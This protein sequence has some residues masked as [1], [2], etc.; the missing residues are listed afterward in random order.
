[1]PHVTNEYENL[2][3]FPDGRIDYTHSRTAPIVSCVIEYRDK[4]LIVKRSKRVSG[5]AGKWDVI[6]GYIDNPNIS[7]IEHTVVELEE[8]IGINKDSIAEIR[9]KDAYSYY[10]SFID[11]TWVVYPVRVTLR[12]RPNIKLNGENSDFI[13][14]YPEDIKKYDV[15]PE[16]HKSVEN[17]LF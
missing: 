15:V 9:I 8:E 4:I 1:M 12:S 2:P 11:K 16:L 6:S 13:W 5:Y 7:E 17:A 10:D 3:R 14:I